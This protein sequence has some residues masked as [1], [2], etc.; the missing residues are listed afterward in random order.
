[1]VLASC[2]GAIESDRIT[3]IPGYRGAL[4]LDMFSGYIETPLPKR[5]GEG[6]AHTHYW[7]TIGTEDAPVVVWQQ[8]GPGG[9]S[10]IGFLTE[11]GPLTLNDDSFA[12]LDYNA[13][14]I[15]TVF[16]N[17]H[18]WHL[19]TSEASQRNTLLFVEHPAPTGFSYCGAHGADCEHDDETQAELA[20]SFYVAFF[21]SYPE[22]AGRPFY[23][24]GE[25]YAG[26]L[27][28]TVAARLLSERNASNAGV[29]PWSLEGFALGNDCPG[30][31]VFT[32]TPYSGWHGTQVSLEV[33][34][35][36]SKDP[37]RQPS[38]CASLPLLSKAFGSPRHLA[39]SLA[40]WHAPR[41]QEARDRPGMPDLVCG[42]AAR[43]E[44]AAARAVCQPP[45]GRCPS[46]QVD[47]GRHVRHGRGVLPV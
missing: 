13:T 21:A 6:T 31:H 36:H 40:A 30:N 45:R 37:V 8:G 47:R 25:S 9:S 19:A 5:S 26:V 16:D 2:L 33:G 27:V 15:P 43:A 1:V 11:N 39:V 42:G 12:T 38:F 18:G 14:G 29:A 24:S 17:P 10:L 3:S 7:L 46:G 4:P 23:M 20:H 35:S 28:P 44:R 34:R 32:C 41:G 22:L